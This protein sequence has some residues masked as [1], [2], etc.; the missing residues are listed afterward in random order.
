[1]SEGKPS[2][3][4]LAARVARL[5]QQLA[6]LEGSERKYRQMVEESPVAIYIIQ[7]G[8]VVYANPSLA[9]QSGYSREEIVGKRPQDF[10]HRDDVAR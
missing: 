10:V 5:E 8:M 1:M 6:D 3:D 7:G 9:R 4:E 2:Y